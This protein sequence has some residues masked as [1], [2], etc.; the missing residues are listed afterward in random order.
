M[1]TWTLHGSAVSCSRRS[2]CKHGKNTMLKEGPL[3]KMFV[4]LIRRVVR[5][6]EYSDKIHTHRRRLRVH[7][8]CFRDKWLDEVLFEALDRLRM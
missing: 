7:C 3:R 1:I 6:W 8:S 2:K 4:L 5:N